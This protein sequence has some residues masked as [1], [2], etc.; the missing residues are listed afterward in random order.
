MRAILTDRF[1]KKYTDKKKKNYFDEEGSV[2]EDLRD[3]DRGGL[4]C[5]VFN[6][7][8]TFFVGAALDLRG[9]RRSRWFRNF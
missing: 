5:N 9:F 6:E 2:G 4:K 8:L 7:P 3:I 1:E